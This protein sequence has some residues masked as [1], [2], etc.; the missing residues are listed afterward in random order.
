MQEVLPGEAPEPAGRQEADVLRGLRLGAVPL[1]LALAL[2]AG[3]GLALWLALPPAD[4]GFLGFV[5][6]VPLLVAL[7]ASRARRGAL[8]GLVFGVAFYGPLLSWLL[9]VTGVGWAALVLGVAAFLALFGAVVPM[10]WR[11][12]APLRTALAVGAAWA[13]VEWFRSAWPFGGWSWVGLGATQHDSPLLSGASVIGALGL[14][15]VLAAV[16]ALVVLA[17]VRF[18]R[19]PRR[20]LLPLGAAVVLAVAPVLVPAADPDGSPV[21]VAVIQGNV[22]F[23]IGTASRI[24]EDTIVARSHADLHS[25]LAGNPPDLAV[26]PENALDRDPT[27]DPVLG[28][29]VAEAIRSVGA[30]TLVGAITETRGGR[31]L[32]EDLLYAADGTVVDRYAKIH[33][34]PFGEYVPFRRQLSWIPDIARVR[35]DLTPGEEPGRFGLGSGSFAAIICF[36]NAFPDLVRDFVTEDT[37]FL[38]VSTNNST[39]GI[40]AAPEQHVVLSELRAV[41]S[42]RWVVHGALSGISAFITPG[43]EVV[44][45]TALFERAV[46]RGEVRHASS[47]TVYDAIGGWLPVA[48]LVLLGIVYLAP[49]RARPRPVPP[50]PRDPDVAV[51]LPTYN[52]RDTVE[53]VIDRVLQVSERVRVIVVD[54]SSP[55]GTGEIVRKVADREPRVTILDRPEKGGLASAYLD[56]FV[57]AVAEGVD[58]IVEMDS[59]LSHRPEDL[60][61]LLEGAAEHHLTIGSRYVPGGAIRNWSPIRRVLSQ[62]G[63]L[64][65]RLLLGIPVADATSGFRVYRWDALRELVTHRLRSEGYGFQ[66]ELAYRAWRRGLSV[67]EVPI[68]FEERRH[69]QS[70]ISRAIVVEALW[71]V[72]VWAVRDRLLRRRPPSRERHPTALPG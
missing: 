67:G 7:R 71:Q 30:P 49:R 40:S 25:R 45:E 64:Y 12:E 60:P 55:D 72:L 51:I 34:L 5:A 29:E 46:L 36:E 2:A 62:G 66:I 61:R 24:I 8:L 3:S 4:L 14:G 70:K 31:L 10:V 42:G 50:L 69:G 21:D 38:V 35:A 9:P 11:D 39:F 47:T 23:E 16:N 19:D 27:R 68:T 28:P 37:G 57:L 43:G 41:E 54:D 17:V 22:P 15:F 20:W 18:G 6:L 33:L 52:E 65:V 26:W 56:G 58:L 59:D 53:E 32:N 1:P 48:F 44:G 13:L 63:N